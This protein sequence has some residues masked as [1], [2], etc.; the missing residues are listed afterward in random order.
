MNMWLL[1]SG[2]EKA[3]KGGEEEPSLK[4]WMHKIHSL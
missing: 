4:V 1:P 3:T 2:E